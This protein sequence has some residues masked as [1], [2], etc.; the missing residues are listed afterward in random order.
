MK[1]LPEKES[2]GG[3]DPKKEKGGIKSMLSWPE[4]RAGLDVHS[5]F[6]FV[7]LLFF[8]SCGLRLRSGLEP[9]PEG[10]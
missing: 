5:I 2:G 3:K 8:T 7:F 10:V 1:S 6:I 4:P 9:E